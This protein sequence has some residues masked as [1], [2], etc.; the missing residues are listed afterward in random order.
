VLAKIIHKKLPIS[1]IRVKKFCAN[2]MFQSANIK[3][4]EFI[5]LASLIEGLERTA[6]YGN[7]KRRKS[8]G[9]TKR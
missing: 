3:K 9:D 7:I 4:T 6:N 2:T 5:A 8:S 1:S